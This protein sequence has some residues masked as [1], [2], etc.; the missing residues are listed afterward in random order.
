MGVQHGSGPCFLYL[1]LHRGFLLTYSF[2]FI[3]VNVSRT[4]PVATM[5]EQIGYN[6]TDTV[7]KVIWAITTGSPG[8]RR[9]V[10]GP[11]F[12]DSAVG[13]MAPLLGEFTY[14]QWNAVY[15]A[16]SFG[17]TAWGVATIFFWLQVPNMTKSYRGI[18]DTSTRRDHATSTSDQ[19]FRAGASCVLRGVS[20]CCEHC[21]S[22]SG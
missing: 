16:L 10:L 9:K 15:S 6:V 22:A 14:A 21:A 12:S 8:S 2:V 5:Y 20:T 18:R 11:S 7:A 13:A 3:I 4:G 1:R 19:V 17:F